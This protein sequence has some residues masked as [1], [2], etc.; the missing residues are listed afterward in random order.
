MPYKP[1]NFGQRIATFAGYNLLIRIGNNYFITPDF[2]L[3]GLFAPGKLAFVC[4]DKRLRL[5]RFIIA[6]KIHAVISGKGHQLPVVNHTTPNFFTIG[7]RNLTDGFVL[8][9]KAYQR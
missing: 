9:S 4:K 2:E 6:V 1:L 3:V 5:V 7:K 8:L